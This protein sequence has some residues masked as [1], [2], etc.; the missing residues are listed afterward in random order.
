MVRQAVA[1]LQVT[2]GIVYL[3]A[4]EETAQLVA[5]ARDAKGVEVP[6]AVVTW[7]SSDPE[8]AR[9][10]TVGVVTA[11]GNGSAQVTG[12]I[13]SVTSTVEVQVE[14]EVASV[15]VTPT[16]ST[17]S[18]IGETVQL[19]AAASDA[20]GY[21]V[22]GAHFT[23]ISQDVNVATV[24]AGGLVRA[25]A[26][27]TARIR[28]AAGGVTATAQI[29]VAQVP[30]AITIVAG[31]GQTGT[32][33]TALPV[34]PAVLVTDVGG[35][36]V[37]AVSVSFA[38]SAD[39]G[40]GG[41][42]ATTNAAGVATV[43]SWTLATLVG[44]NTLTA[45]AGALSVTIS[46]TGTPGEPAALR[47][48]TMPSEVRA[49]VVPSPLPVLRLED[50]YGNPVSRAGV[51]VGVAIQTSGDAWVSSGFV[52]TDANGVA[53]FDRTTFGGTPGPAEL[54]F[55]VVDT[56]ISATFPITL[57]AGAPAKITRS[58]G[59]G[60]TAEVGS[61]LGTAPAVIITDRFDNPIAAV[62]VTFTASGGGSVTGGTATTDAN[63]VATVGS[64]T[65]ATTAGPNTLTASAGGLSTSFSATGTP[66]APA[67]ITRTAGDE[68][69]A[70]VASVL[71][72]A[73]AVTIR[74]QY[75]NPLAGVSITFTASGDGAVMGSP[76]TTDANGVATV[77]SWTLATKAGVNTLTAAVGA[78]RTTFA[79]TGTP[80]APAQLA[81]TTQ[82]AATARS[83]VAFSRQPVVQL[84][85]AHG[86]PTA[87]ADVPV[88]AAAPLGTLG[89]AAVVTTDANGAAVFSDLSIGGTLGTRWL[90]FTS[91]GLSGAA[92]EE[93]ELT[94]GP[95]A[96]LVISPPANVV[97][98]AQITPAV[99]VS[100]L[101]AYGN[102]AADATDPVTVTL[103]GTPS[104][105]TLSGTT[106]VAAVGGV[107][108]FSDLRID[109]TGAGYALVASSGTLPAATSAG[110]NV[111]HGPLDRFRVEAAGGGP[112]GVQRSGVSFDVRVTAQDAYGN[113]VTSFTGMVEF[114]A[115]GGVISTGHTSAAFTAGVLETHSIT[116]ASGQSA[117]LIASN[118]DEPDALSM[119]NPFD[120][121]EPPTAV[122]EGPSGSSAPGDAY[123]A[124]YSTSGSPQ[125]FTL[126]A[127]GGVLSNDNLGFPAATIT[128]FGG[129]DL[130]GD[131]ADHE[132]GS[133]VAPLPGHTSGSLKVDADGSIAFTPP[134]D[135][136]GEYVF[137]YRLSN[138][139][140][141]SDAQ[142]TIAVGER[143]V[144]SDDAYPHTLVGNVPI[145]TATSTQFRVTDND[146]GDAATFAIVGQNNGKATLNADG[147]FSFTPN[148]GY[149]GPA[150]FTY[151][152]SNG[153]GTSAPATVRMT[154]TAPIWFV[155]AAA[156]ADGDGRFDAPFNSLST[157]AAKNTGAGNNPS[158][159]DRI[160][161]YSGSY[162]GG[163]TLLANQRLI[164]QGATASLSAIAGVTWPADA[165]P[166]PVM[167][168]AAP[169]ITTA[170]ASTNGITLGS[171]N[172]LRGFN[173][174][175]VTGSALS[176]TG[177]G[178]L[179]VSEVEINTTGQALDLTTGT[180]S[181]SFPVL[182]STGGTNNVYLKSVATSSPVMLGTASDALSG[183]TGDALKIDGGTGSFTYAGSISNTA[184][185]AV[186][187]TNK[188][189]GAV[190][191]SGDINPG[192]AGR[193]IVATNNNGT[194]LT[195]SGRQRINASEGVSLT[196]NPGSTVVFSADSLQVTTTG[197]D[198][199]VVTNSGTL[200]MTGVGHAISST[201]GTALRVEN[202]TIGSGGLKFKR[203]DANGG[204]NGIVLVN[205]GAS[206]G[207]TITGDGATPG[208][209]GTIR[210]TTGMD[211]AVA[212][213]GI[214]LS[215][216]RDVVLN[217]MKL[218]DHP[219]H[220][221]RGSGVTNFTL[222]R[223]QI[224][225]VN[226]TNSAGGYNEGSISFDN[227]T[228]QAS[229][230]NSYIGGGFTDN[231]RVV[232]SAGVLDRIVFTNDTIG[233]TGVYGND[234][235]LLESQGTAVINATIADNVFT[236]AVG[237]LFQFALQ[238]ASRGDLVLERNTFHN[239]Q[240]NSASGGGGVTVGSGGGATASA[241]L[242][243]RI[244][245]N[246]F[247]G[248]LGSALR[249]Y[250][251]SGV[252]VYSGTIR[253]NVIGH[254][255][256]V[257]L[258]S[259]QGAA[260]SLA[261][262]GGGSH[263]AL[264]EHNKFYGYSL[265]GVELD[266]G[267]SAMG[268][269]G[270]LDATVRS[271]TIAN[272]GPWAMADVWLWTGAL[273]VDAHQVCLD[274]SA[275]VLAGTPSEFGNVYLHQDQKTTVRLPG[276]VGLKDDNSA[277]S[278][279][280]ASKNVGSGPPVVQVENSVSAG[281]GG[282]TNTVPAG[283]ACMQPMM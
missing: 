222:H 171:G 228:G 190:V 54:G 225:G 9:V 233:H 44:A 6:D 255:G 155:N 261:Q 25:A 218:N 220:A 83:G 181:G 71:G 134:D 34:S 206:G 82:P 247:Q 162:T 19:R 216:T 2:P 214:F 160:F 252:G 31:D 55:G 193:G 3:G 232:T 215:S 262:I 219:N 253:N 191:L 249:V 43:G 163:L 12:R 47:A 238:S 148:T 30:A 195:F 60:Q 33:A 257:A 110:F 217:W 72:T 260:L 96:A 265:A 245:N 91:A 275:N 66:G 73:P 270:R 126:A 32:V 234:G 202:T 161:L 174:G 118:R 27:G 4:L 152:A 226:G 10:S 230:T 166:A 254:P 85:D 248:A 213:N 35:A 15:R 1:S 52:R 13:G 50:R 111:T 138:D 149:R 5:L 239:T 16:A 42:P 37:P 93:F 24:S 46:A 283:S 136:T 165:G 53:T 227:L 39:G 107:A 241:S 186:N 116:M 21:G 280:L 187:I 159:G 125:T 236:G 144:A 132:A 150:S 201:N 139:A 176:G 81:V 137:H 179:T 266:V 271:N 77:G 282:F 103:G 251:G 175:N 62:E 278:A 109:K 86:N 97:A 8:V 133:K 188:I 243:Y 79:A 154:V 40:V 89:G 182:R 269:S 142:V 177:F 209:G 268:G 128:S 80:G 135:F 240:P 196:N 164:G 65:L 145:N 141:F 51:E 95:A 61:V 180:L 208:S 242:T 246:S 59:D 212:G 22:A 169:T 29:T 112:I 203:I 200:Q 41:S 104:G 11:V 129:S 14:Q 130:R 26:S 272:P 189:G 105:G 115:V 263:T 98:S 173:L 151:T 231:V 74:D 84:L 204:S 264:V 87:I 244:E 183:A 119:S 67:K 7:T 20:N 117:E 185:R 92:S 58:A 274:L 210:N 76:A 172:T 131:V 45:T 153:F 69:T 277:V 49:D 237:D 23:W 18:A 223:T 167:G 28:V 147:T 17:L 146:R 170:V 178:T 100:L 192:V 235:L 156:E 70:T 199:F 273:E 121:Q 88:A 101:D 57:L 113:T 211:L 197:G 38:A 127:P 143:P 281:G 64:W 120:V 75:D 198:G 90:V 48:V 194:T 108:T 106:T 276:Y 68:Q 205:T 123:H 122:N 56:N 36:P 259:S 158:A 63:G 114:I 102:P 78:L 267:D 258:G 168:G 207:L 229:F 250:K 221:I 94:A 184:L 279:F 124:F 224:T 157:L 256:S 99:H 140:G